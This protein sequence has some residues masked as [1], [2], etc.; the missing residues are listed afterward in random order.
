L[1][2]LLG[3]PA[4][5]PFDADRDLDPFLKRVTSVNVVEFRV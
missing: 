4:T 2:L 5:P 1:Q 3:P